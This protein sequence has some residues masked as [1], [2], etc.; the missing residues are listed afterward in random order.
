LPEPGS[1]KVVDF[2]LPQR[3][4]APPAK[5]AADAPGEGRQIKIRFFNS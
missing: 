1:V 3:A 4:P 5:P 2:S